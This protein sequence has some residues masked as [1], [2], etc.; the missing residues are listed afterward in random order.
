M[1]VST[2]SLSMGLDCSKINGVLH[3]NFP[4]CIESYVQQIGRSGRSGQNSTCITFL[5]TND[6]YFIR[7]KT[8][9]DH[10]FSTRILNKF[11]DF[12]TLDK[13]NFENPLLSSST[14]N[15]KF[16]QNN[17]YYVV[18]DD[19]IQKMFGFKS[20]EF[21]YLANLLRNFSIETEEF[22]FKVLYTLC[23]NVQIKFA[24]KS[25]GYQEMQKDPDFQFIQS[26]GRKVT[27]GISFS[28]LDL[29]NSK[30]WSIMET[31]AYLE[32]LAEKHRGYSIKTGY[33]IYFK[34]ESSLPIS[35]LNHLLKSYLQKVVK[36]NL[37]TRL[38]RI[39]LFYYILNGAIKHSDDNSLQSE[40][41]QNHI[42]EYFKRDEKSF[43][44]DYIKKKELQRS[45]PLE[46]I[47]ESGINCLFIVI[48]R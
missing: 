10:Y 21:C 20:K 48:F 39:D 47:T 33:G 34:I 46:Y 37:Q 41:V 6:F 42:K 24:K 36:H 8:F 35:K 13:V 44:E 12:I 27:N 28:I 19:K 18:R 40:F 31:I 9:I 7:G 14:Q 2:V 23:I 11:I 30:K 26:G 25:N 1:I 4:S 45:V 15:S 22:N 16:K 3:Y 38:L 29:S 5:K 43:L 32:Q 17:K